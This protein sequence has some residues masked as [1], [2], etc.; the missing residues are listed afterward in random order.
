M[1][2]ELC[3]CGNERAEYKIINGSRVQNNSYSFY[4]MIYYKERFT[5]GGSLINNLFVLTAAHCV[6][7][8]I[9]IVF[10]FCRIR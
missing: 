7:V 4:V 2:S 8:R 1:I 6:L 3:T 10:N 5:C 9:K